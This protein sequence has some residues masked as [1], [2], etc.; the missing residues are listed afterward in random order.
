[1]KGWVL[2]VILILMMALFWGMGYKTG[3][4]LAVNQCNKFI[5][6]HYSEDELIN[7]LMNVKNIVPE[8]IRLNRVIR[9]IPTNYHIAGVEQPNLRQV[10]QHKMKLKGLKC[11]CI[12]CREVKNKDTS[13]DNLQIVIRT[14]DSSNGK[15]Y[16]ISMEN[17]DKSLIY[18]FCRLRL[19]KQAGICKNY[20]KNCRKR[21]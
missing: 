3:N 12:R 20:K 4:S 16:F 5:Y 19:T 13:I 6:E 9:D 2:V 10:I 14:Y 8:W 17:N 7:L 11:K 15:E 18:G 1:M 21:D